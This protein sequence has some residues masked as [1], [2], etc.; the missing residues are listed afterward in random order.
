MPNHNGIVGAPIAGP[1][2]TTQSLRD[3]QGALREIAGHANEVLEKVSGLPINSFNGPSRKHHILDE[4]KKASHPQPSEL[5]LLISSEVLG[6]SFLPRTTVGIIGG[7]GL[8]KSTLL[9]S[10]L[11]KK[12]SP[13]SNVGRGTAAPT[14]IV[15]HPHDYIEATLSFMPE[16][17]VRGMIE[18]T[19]ELLERGED[20][21]ILLEPE[22][23]RDPSYALVTEAF[24]V[25]RQKLLNIKKGPSSVQED[26]QIKEDAHIRA[27]LALFPGIDKFFGTTITI[28]ENDEKKFVRALELYVGAARTHKGPKKW[29]LLTQLVIKCNSDVLAD[30]TILV[31]LPG[32]GDCSPTI[33]RVTENVKLKLDVKLVAVLPARASIEEGVTDHMQEEITRRLQAIQ[34]HGDG[35][36]DGDDPS[37]ACSSGLAIIMT[38]CDALT[39]GT[40]VERLEED[41]DVGPVLKSNEEFTRLAQELTQAQIAL[42]DK[43]EMLE[44]LRVREQGAIELATRTAAASDGA[45]GSSASGCKRALPHEPRSMASVKCP[46]LDGSGPDP[47]ASTSSVTVNQDDGDL[48][49]ILKDRQQAEREAK[50]LQELAENYETRRLY[51][52]WM[53][54]Y[55][56]SGV[57]LR[58]LFHACTVVACND[59][60]GDGDE[61]MNE[62]REDYSLP[63][64]ATGAEDFNRLSGDKGLEWQTGIPALRQFIRRLGARAQDRAVLNLLRPLQTQVKSTYTLLTATDREAL[65]DRV[66]LQKLALSQRWA[67]PEAAN[68]PPAVEMLAGETTVGSV[69]P[70]KGV[71]N[72]LNMIFVEMVEAK[73]RE[74]RNNLEALRKMCEKGATAAAES[75]QGTAQSLVDE[76]IHWAKHRAV[77]KNNGTY[78]GVKDYNVALAAPLVAIAGRTIDRYRRRG[79]VFGLRKL[80]QDK[81]NSFFDK[82]HNSAEK[83]DNSLKNDVHLRIFD[84][85]E[86]HLSAGLLRIKTTGNEL[87]GEKRHLSESAFFDRAVKD[88]LQQAYDAAK[89]YKGRKS[90]AK[91]K[92]QFVASVGTAA[93]TM[94]HDMARDFIKHQSDFIDEVETLVLTELK[95]VAQECEVE[96][97]N[98]W[99]VPDG[100]KLQLKARADAAQVV[101]DIEERLST[102]ESELV[103]QMEQSEKDVPTCHP[104]SDEWR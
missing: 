27:V 99:V 57:Q 23:K 83:C 21:K 98:A 88:C 67:S 50:Q 76:P 20:K 32:S 30:G 31:D 35:V 17:E 39:R 44:R 40:E 11:G 73:V 37:H 82:V 42:A 25:T 79:I 6:P 52:A 38:H 68:D 5:K 3:P 15:Y 2:L 104:P 85:R 81:A 33:L 69:G 64:F 56:V 55:K 18:T 95:R 10:I 46:R 29:A 65:G 16:E 60:D 48:A 92:T 74:A 54:R 66:A 78:T 28:R 100:D 49:T 47:T 102:L 58:R 43:N 97:S 94:F 53:S 13:T 62:E 26:G 8:G 89:Q 84:C 59:D 19:L 90:I 22:L 70:V 24:D 51:L 96:I 93:G 1:S 101:K 14:I 72:R 4:I 80:A 34:D 103:Q 87:L 7:T 36:A 63:V 71:R 75:A 45:A 9:S 41:D 12:I 61:T 77:L 91:M 86:K